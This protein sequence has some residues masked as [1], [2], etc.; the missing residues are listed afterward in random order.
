M[1]NRASNASNS[2]HKPVIILII[3]TVVAAKD[4]VIFIGKK[5]I[6]G[7]GHHLAGRRATLVPSGHVQ[8]QEEAMTI[9]DR[10]GM[11]SKRIGVQEIV[12]QNKVVGH[13][14]RNGKENTNRERNQISE[15][16]W[17]SDHLLNSVGL[18]F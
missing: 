12:V 1:N 17:E 15:I 3:I 16:K 10:L 14:R 6:R 2:T 8:I 11:L 7:T 4:V 9:I 13:D 5:G 18:T